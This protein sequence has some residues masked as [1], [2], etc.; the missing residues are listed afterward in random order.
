MRKMKYGKGEIWVPETEKY[1]IHNN[2]KG[3]Q[4]EYIL[5]CPKG[6]S[7]DR[8]WSEEILQALPTV[9]NIPLHS[10]KS[11]VR[12]RIIIGDY[13]VTDSSLSNS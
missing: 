9:R 3:Y 6:P 11:I 7:M 13:M 10:E 5:N 8:D 12:C 4:S 1:D 2:N